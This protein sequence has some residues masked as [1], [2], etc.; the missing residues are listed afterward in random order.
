MLLDGFPPLL[1]VSRPCA[2]N[3][4]VHEMRANEM[5]DT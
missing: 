5:L 4:I 2:E 1:E 3:H